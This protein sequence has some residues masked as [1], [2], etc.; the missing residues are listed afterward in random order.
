MDV[1]LKAINYYWSMSTWKTI[2]LPVLYLV[3]FLSF[4]SIFRM[5]F[6]VCH[7]KSYAAKIKSDELSGF[8]IVLVF[9]SLCAGLAI[10]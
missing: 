10:L 6:N 8:H 7:M 3:S 9:L 1:V 5:R 2:A 4:F